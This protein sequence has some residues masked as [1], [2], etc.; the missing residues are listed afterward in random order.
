MSRMDSQVAILESTGVS[1]SVS[2]FYVSDGASEYHL[3]IRPLDIGTVEEQLDRIEVAYSEALF[4]LELHRNT[5]VTRRFYCSDVQ[6][7]RHALKAH[8]LSNPRAAGEPCAA[9]WI[10]QAPMPP[11]KV[12]MWAYHISDELTP[13]IKSQ[14][15]S[16]TILKRGEL[17]HHWTAGLVNTVESSP[18]GQT[19][20]IFHDYLEHLSRHNLR[21]ADH[22]VRTWFYVQDVDSNY[23][24]MVSARKE[25]FLKHGLT[26]DT[27]F[28]AS[29]G[30]EGRSSDIRAKVMLDSYAIAGLRPGQVEYIAA[31]D[32]LSPTHVYGVTFERATS[33]A[34]QDRKHIFISGTASIDKDG[35][36]VHAGDVGH[37]L[38]RTL[39]NVEALLE[40]A[41]SSLEDMRIFLVYVRD[42]SDQTFALNRMRERFGDV[43]I[44]VVVAP[45][46]RPGWLIEVEG[47]AVVQS[48]NPDLPR[49]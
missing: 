2:S 6:N 35:N 23:G 32:H 26:A 10:G 45:V 39:E 21:L 37:Q 25:I 13:L 1:V 27:H 17:A 20:G 9:S 19:Q 41:G 40:Q 43:P 29:T 30:I 16:T 47:V 18:Y 15:D 36:I 33:V 44:E 14:S 4:E 48:C 31:L 38:E 49:F 24:G 7:A 28:I 5:A 46:C 11:A 42:P 34:Y 8:A 22:V 12:S 3:L